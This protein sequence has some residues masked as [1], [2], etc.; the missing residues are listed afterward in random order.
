[1]ENK[2]KVSRIIYS[3]LEALLRELETK[4]ELDILIYAIRDYEKEGYPLDEFKERYQEHID[5]LKE[6]LYNGET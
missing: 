1:M 5:E 6:R 3:T 2:E 4:E